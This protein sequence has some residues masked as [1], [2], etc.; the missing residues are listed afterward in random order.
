MSRLVRS[1]TSAF[2]AQ[3]YIDTNNWLKSKNHH[4]TQYNTLSF[5]IPHQIDEGI[6]YI[7][8]IHIYYGQHD[9]SS[10]LTQREN[11]TWICVCVEIKNLG[12][13]DDVFRLYGDNN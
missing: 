13:S 12:R 6:Y 3:Q 4:F 7:A 1:N 11:K 8:H 10:S 5:S 2:M 9:N